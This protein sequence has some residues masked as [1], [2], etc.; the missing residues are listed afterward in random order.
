MNGNYLL[1]TNIAIA[2]LENEAAVV[3]AI[4]EATNVWLPSIALGELC[5]GARK[6]GRPQHNLSHVQALAEQLTIV[7]CGAQTA[8]H[9]GEIKEQLRAKGRPIPDNDLWIAAIA[10]EHGLTLWTRDNH[11]AEVPDLQLKSE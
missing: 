2:F 6:S 8:W 1:D 3:T 4:R 11:F 7:E 9:Y 10:K 5:Y